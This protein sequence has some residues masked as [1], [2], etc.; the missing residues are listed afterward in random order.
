[1]AGDAAVSATAALVPPTKKKTYNFGKK[2]KSQYGTKQQKNLK[3]YQRYKL[4]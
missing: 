2:K 3:S 1:M 4:E